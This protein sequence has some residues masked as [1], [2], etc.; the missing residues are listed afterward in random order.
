MRLIPLSLAPVVAVSLVAACDSGHFQ[1]AIAPCVCETSGCSDQACPITV[2]LDNTC[3]GE[4]PFAEVLVGDHVEAAHVVP[5]EAKQLCSRIEPGAE[6]ELWV[7]GGPWV[8]GPLRER[9]EN[10]AETRAIV[11]QCVEAQ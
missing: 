9:C 6:A 10:A 2:T 4:M 3:E 5:L 11:L 1:G 7:R 8:W